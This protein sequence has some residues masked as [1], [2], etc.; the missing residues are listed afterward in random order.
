MEAQDLRNELMIVEEEKESLEKEAGEAK[1]AL[2]T[3]ETSHERLNNSLLSAKTNE[4][5]L[6]DEKIDLEGIVDD[7]RHKL[8]KSGEESFEV[9]EDRRE[10]SGCEFGIFWEEI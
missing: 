2:R 4:Q 1:L 7:L 3:L 8:Q 6:K 9:Q 5:V 10:V